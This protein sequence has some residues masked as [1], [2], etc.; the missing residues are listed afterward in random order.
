MSTQLLAKGTTIKINPEIFKPMKR[1]DD[2]GGSNGVPLFLKD[3]VFK[4]VGYDKTEYLGDFYDCEILRTPSAMTDADGTV[5]EVEKIEGTIK[6]VAKDCIRASEKISLSYEVLQSSKREERI[7]QLQ[8]EEKELFAFRTAKK[9]EGMKIS[10]A[11]LTNNWAAISSIRDEVKRLSKGGGGDLVYINSIKQSVELPAGLLGN[12][13]KM[14][15]FILSKI[16]EYRASLRQKTSVSTNKLGLTKVNGVYTESNL[17]AKL[18]DDRIKNLID[19]HKKPTTNDNYVGIEIE[20]IHACSV[21]DLKAKFVSKRMHNVVNVG[22]DGSIGGMTEGETGSEIRFMS[23]E[24]DLRTNLMKLAE[25]LNDPEV[26]AKVN[27]TCGLHVHLDMRNRN[28]EKS[29]NN[30]WHVQKL[31]RFS[32]PLSR[33]NNKYCVESPKS[34]KENGER[35]S[36]INSSAYAKHKTLEIRVHQGTVDVTDMFNWVMFL[37]SVVDASKVLTK[38][39]SNVSELKVDFPNFSQRGLEYIEKKMEQYS[40]PAKVSL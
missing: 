31:L 22:T 33:R 37:T 20:F 35:R 24:S 12:K 10:S 38:E 27:G 40:K 26:D 29:Y 8:K 9:K 21:K 32:Q 16:S 34:M 3:F 1:L 28:V 14:E 25:V 2:M 18:Q 4:I 13:E 5:Y 11:T 6:L 19:A 23:K 7:K 15:S 36:T 39:Y 30:L 17:Y